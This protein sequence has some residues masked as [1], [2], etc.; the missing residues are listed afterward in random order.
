MSFKVAGYSFMGSYPVDEIGD[1]KNWPGLYAILCRRG[2]RHYLV[3]VG[4]SDNLQSELEE[5]DGRELWER[6]CSGDLVIAVKYTMEIHQ[7]ERERMER[8]IRRRHNPPC[9]KSRSFRPG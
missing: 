9:R 6:N 1:I 4:E 8:K 3:D 5:N 2:N 7:T